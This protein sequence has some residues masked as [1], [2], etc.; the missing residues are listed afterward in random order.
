MRAGRNMFEAQLTQGTLLRKIVEA[1]KDL[2]TDVNWE[3]TAEG[4]QCQVTGRAGPGPGVL[5]DPTSTPC[6][7]LTCSKF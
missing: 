2:V 5:S 3:V 1:L 4:L 6:C 7:F